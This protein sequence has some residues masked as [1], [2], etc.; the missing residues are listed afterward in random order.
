MEEGLSPPGFSMTLSGSSAAQQER[1]MIQMR[2][3][4]GSLVLHI[5]VTVIRFGTGSILWVAARKARW[6][7]PRRED[8]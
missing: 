7:D 1:P 4:E 2:P 3:R 8:V 6:T 5:D